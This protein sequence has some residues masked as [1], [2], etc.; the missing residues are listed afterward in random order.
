[1]VFSRCWYSW[2]LNCGMDWR[3]LM[4]LGM[5]FQIIGA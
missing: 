2:V 1:L 3:V 4:S 5:E